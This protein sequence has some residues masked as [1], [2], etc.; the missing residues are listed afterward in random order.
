MKAFAMTNPQGKDPRPSPSLQ[1]VAAYAIISAI[2]VA[3]ALYLLFG[4]LGRQMDELADMSCL[5]GG[6][7]RDVC[8]SPEQGRQWYR[9]N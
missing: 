5:R 6:N 3:A 9:G 7:S 8:L 1:R 2:G 4:P